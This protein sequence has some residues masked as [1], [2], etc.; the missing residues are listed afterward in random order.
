MRVPISQLGRIQPTGGAPTIKAAR[1]GG[2][3]SIQHGLDAV[4]HAGDVIASVYHHVQ[5]AADQKRQQAAEMRRQAKEN[6]YKEDVINSL[7][8]NQ[9]ARQTQKKLL[10]PP[11][12]VEADTSKYADPWAVDSGPSESQQAG[13]AAFGD[14]TDTSV[15]EQGVDWSGSEEAA[16]VGEGSD[17][18][19]GE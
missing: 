16:A 11:P 9:A 1:V 3:D 6:A 7:A 18:A 5:A 15:D 10:S 8:G 13:D 2:F 12:M 4:G 14:T 19:G 17:S